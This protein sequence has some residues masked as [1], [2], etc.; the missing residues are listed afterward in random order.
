M[1]AVGP[2]PSWA[3]RRA[4]PDIANTTVLLA[5]HRPYL[6]GG[7]PEPG[8]RTEGRTFSQKMILYRDETFPAAAW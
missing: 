8:K 1:Y 6:I 2:V 4:P 3:G 7:V 5:D